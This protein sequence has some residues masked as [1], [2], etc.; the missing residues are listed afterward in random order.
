MKFNRADRKAEKALDALIDLQSDYMD[1]IQK[2]EVIYELQAAIDTVNR[3]RTS[4]S[5][6][7]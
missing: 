1:E 6:K 4:L 3:I 7:Y 5:L 2:A